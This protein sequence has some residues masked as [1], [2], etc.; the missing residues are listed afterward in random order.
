[1]RLSLVF[2]NAARSGAAFF[3]AVE[4]KSK[5]SLASPNGGVDQRKSPGWHARI[6]SLV[7]R[8][9]RWSSNGGGGDPKKQ[10]KGSNSL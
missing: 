10:T 8:L 4:A 1:M 9:A 7:Q 3:V 5:I 6:G 2:F